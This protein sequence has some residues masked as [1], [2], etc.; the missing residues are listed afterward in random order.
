MNTTPLEAAALQLLSCSLD[1]AEPPFHIRDIHEADVINALK[2]SRA[3]DV[4]EMDILMLKDQNSSLASPLT[5]I[6]NQ[7]FSQGQQ[8]PTVTPIFKSGNPLTTCMRWR[9]SCLPGTL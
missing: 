1:V 9:C 7:L 4:Y 3:K 5:N 6:L 8:T 2:T